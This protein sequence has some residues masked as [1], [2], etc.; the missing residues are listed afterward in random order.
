[1]PV[2]R[3]YLAGGALIAGAIVLLLLSW[4]IAVG[5]HL[6][7]RFVQAVG[8]R[9]ESH[10]DVQ[11]LSVSIFPRP[12]LS[13]TGLVLRHKNRTDVP[14]LVSVAS[15]SAEAAVFGFFAH[16]LRLS[17]VDIEGLEINIPPGG[18]HIDSDAGDHPDQSGNTKPQK[19]SPIVIAN[20]MSER[21]VLRILRRKPGKQPRVFE[22]RQL[23][24]QDVGA[25]IPWPFRAELTNPTPPGE[26]QT[27]GTFGPWNAH[28][29]SNTPLAA[30]YQFNKADLGVFDEIQGVLASTGAFKGVLERIEVDGQAGVPEFAL[31][32][33]KNPVSLQTR[34]H[35]IVDGT[36]GDTLLQPVDAQFLDTKIHA[37]GGVV[38]RDGEQGRTVTLD[39]VMNEARLE[40]VLRLAVKSRQPAM[41][42]ALNL[43]A[44]FVLPP[45]H[46]DAISKLELDGAFNV[47]AARFTKSQLQAKVNEFSAKARGEPGETLDPIASDFKGRF[48][49]RE[50][51]I[52]FSSVTFAMPGAKVDVAGSYAMKSAGLDFHG[53]VRLNA[54]LS[55]LTTGVKTFFLKLIEGLFRH[56][57]ITVIPITI[58]GSASDPKVRLDFAKAIKG[59]K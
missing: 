7:R 48:K 8:E 14:P 1:M 33:V 24:M 19:R 10:V 4:P 34:F 46:R 32:D 13:G 23:A 38:E 56:E 28:D 2:N 44:A 54:K 49:M 25:D 36:N 59:A 16:P 39:I 21:A 12:R 53:T 27:H 51:V 6:K 17:R 37:S 55:K 5:P 50:G 11:T 40:D 41:T 31:S 43:T 20:L 30:E 29:P 3:R 18:M 35:S 9:F 47:A 22:I 42:G 58:G 52:H 26:I 57:D 15:F 45:G